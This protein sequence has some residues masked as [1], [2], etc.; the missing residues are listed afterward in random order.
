MWTKRSNAPGRALH[1]H[2]RR[3]GAKQWSK[4]ALAGMDDLKPYDL[5]QPFNAD[6]ILEGIST[7]SARCRRSRLAIR[8]GDGRVP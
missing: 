7:E 8:P 2:P 4:G 3:H 1:D 6:E 5:S